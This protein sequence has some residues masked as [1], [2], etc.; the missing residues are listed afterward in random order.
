M[1]R[2]VSEQ[3]LC[4]HCACKPLVRSEAEIVEQEYL[5]PGFEGNCR[6]RLMEAVQACGL[7]ERQPE[8]FEPR[9]GLEAVGA[10]EALGHTE[11]RHG[12]AEAAS[13]ELTAEV[14]EQ[15]PGVRE[16]A[17][18][19]AEQAGHVAGGGP[20]FEDLERQR[21]SGEGVEDGG[22]VERGAEEPSVDTS[23]P[24]ICGRVKTGHFAGSAS[25]TQ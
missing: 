15:V 4:G 8:A 25:E 9:R 14:A 20:P 5:E 19:R 23:K 1:E 24:A 21:R 11:L 10:R 18:G 2:L 3:Y 6:D 12:L 22:D 13:G 7:L 16:T 17:S